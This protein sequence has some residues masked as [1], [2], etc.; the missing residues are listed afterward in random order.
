MFFFNSRSLSGDEEG[1]IA[2]C[3]TINRRT[4]FYLTSTLNSTFNQDYDFS[5]AKS[6]EFSKHR[7]LQYVKNAV[8]SNLS[9]AADDHYR[10]LHDAL[11]TAIDE[12]ISLKEC[13][14]YR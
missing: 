10:D 9:A 7:S 14:I 12:E 6:E 5:D 2:L 3:D 4:L 11:W 1:A 8:Q 13:D